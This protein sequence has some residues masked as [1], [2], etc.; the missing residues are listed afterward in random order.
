MK[1]IIFAWVL[2]FSVLTA[3]AQ[4]AGEVS[5]TRKV[6][7]KQGDK[8]VVELEI[9]VG[10][11]AVARN[12]SWTILPELS[13]ADRGSVI[14]FPHVLINGKYQ[15]HMMERRE[16][17]SGKHWSERKAHLVIDAAESEGQTFVYRYAV[18]YEEWM[19]QATLVLRQV[20]TAPG[21]VRRVFTV[22]VNGAVDAD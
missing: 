2:L 20:L 4:I 19:R 12:E 13:T 22:D 7:A 11:N 14:L 5:V 3:S 10:R 21:N 9:G 15:Q 16:R 17:L 1:K 18:D 6:L 8:L